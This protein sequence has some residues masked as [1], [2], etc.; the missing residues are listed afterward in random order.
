MRIPPKFQLHMDRSMVKDGMISHV[1]VEPTEARGAASET[2]KK[3]KW[4]TPGLRSLLQQNVRCALLIGIQNFI[5]KK[6]NY[7]EIIAFTPF[8]DFELDAE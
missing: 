5:C 7:H 8:V 2:I 3:M 1:D 6:I 4:H